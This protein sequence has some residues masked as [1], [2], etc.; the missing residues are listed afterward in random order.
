MKP[1]TSHLSVRVAPGPAP[2]TAAEVQ[3]FEDKRLVDRV[4]ESVPPDHPVFGSML[5]LLSIE[6]TD[7]IDTAAVTLG[8]R[9]RL[10]LGREFVRTNCRSDAHLQMLVMHELL[11]VLLGHTR[12]LTAVTLDE[13]WASDCLINAQLCRLYP[14]R[15]FTS[16]FRNLAAAEGPWSLIA[17]PRGWP[18]APTFAPGLL[19]DVHRRLYD[20]HGVVD[21]E[22][23]AL[24]RLL[25]PKLDP[26]EA[27][28]LIGSHGTGAAAAGTRRSHQL[29]QQPD[30]ASTG[31]DRHDAEKQASGRI[32]DTCADDATPPTDVT[33]GADPGSL[34][35]GRDALERGQER[36]DRGTES[37]D[38]EPGL[39]G[40]DPNLTRAARAAL[41]GV[42][43]LASAATAGNGGATIEVMRPL[44]PSA[45]ARKALGAL[46]VRAADEVGEAR[47]R[48][49]VTGVPALTPMPQP[50]DRRAQVQRLCGA[51]PLLWQAE[52]AHLDT[53]RCSDV[54][55]Y[56]DVSGSMREWVPVLLAAVRDVGTLVRSPVLGFSTRVYP[57]TRADLVAGRLQTTGGTHIDCVADHMLRTKVRHA[58]LITDGHVQDLDAELGRRLRH[59]R[60]RVH[61]G[62]IHGGVSGFCRALG[63]SV[64]QLPPLRA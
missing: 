60:V 28:R 36:R 10:L 49:R 47:L 42:R 63:W 25:G 32:G 6:P 13:N 50:G 61:L 21:F 39:L 34:D 57:I 15:E 1:P 23:L 46:L 7:T 40:R 22:L 37:L 4:R 54:T 26:G 16:F 18:Q 44:E 31:E 5:Q 38:G 48:R 51:Q 14:G 27:H 56:V 52:L 59:A 11:H 45:K 2:E 8:P 9:S 55:V 24:L 35:Q 17:P 3:R 12:L 19:G 20:E 41:S 64:V 58:A 29:P 30:D 62:L 33:P 53:T 43:W